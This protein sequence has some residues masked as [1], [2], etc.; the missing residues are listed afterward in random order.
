MI[1]KIVSGG[2]TGVDRGGLDWAMSNNVACGGM[3][4]KG[5]RAEDGRIPSRYVGL[6]ET[7]SRNYQVR[8]RE[9]VRLSDG[10]L[11]IYAGTLNGGTDLT[12][13]ICRKEGKPVFCLNL[14]VFD[15]SALVVRGD[16]SRW[17]ASRGVRVLNVAGPRESKQA[18]IQKRTFEVLSCLLGS[19]G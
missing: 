17:I 8:T 7:G 5:R 12:R 16:F 14:E 9:N 10:T 18:G 19:A 6:I 13:V 1:E 11:I 2:Q 3:V 4:P 15:N